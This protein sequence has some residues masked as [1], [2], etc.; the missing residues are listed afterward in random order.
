[1][2]R[3][4]HLFLVPGDSPLGLRLPL[5]S[6]P[7]VSASE[8]PQFFP[9]DPTAALP[10]L[11]V[12]TRDPALQ[13]RGGDERDKKPAPGESAP[14]IVRSALCVEPRDGRMHIFT[15]PQF[16]TEDYLDL[17]AAIEDTAAHLGTPVVIEGYTPP[18]DHRLNRISVTPDPGVIEVNVHPAHNWSELVGL[19]TS[20]YED[21]R[22]CRLG[23]EKFMLD[24]RHTGTGGG[25]H[26]VLG[27]A[28]PADSPF[29]RR[30]DLLRSM[31]GYWLNHP[32]LS[33]LFSGMFIGPTS[34]APRIDEGRNDNLYELEIAFSQ[35][36]LPGGHHCPPWLVDRI[37]RH[38]LVDLTGNTHRAEFCIDKLYSPDSA[39]GRLGLV[40]MRGFEM[41]PHPRMSLTQQL[42][43]RAFV[44][45]FW[46]EPYLHEP[47]DWGTQLHDR[48][49]LP[50][51]VSADF[52]EVLDDLR[53][54]GY[55]FEPEWF[56]PH[57][58]FRYPL[59][60]RVNYASVDI[61]LRQAIEPW[62]VLG[63]EPAGGATARFVDSS[64]ERLQVKVDSL[65]SDRYLIACNGRR[66]PLQPT[67]IRGQWVAGVRY[68]AWQ[69]PSC[70]HPTIPVHTPLVFDVFDTWSGRSI[71]GCAYHV[72]HPG[73]RHYESFPVNANE[74]EARRSARFF[75]FGHTPGPMAHPAEESNRQF[76]TT[77]DL[78]RPLPFDG[79]KN[80]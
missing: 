3:G 79:R 80:C 34:Q 45:W 1:M 11:P 52:R 39:S 31:L 48:F 15:P 67:S 66:I 43:V 28:T 70:L 62:Y 5:T 60:G 49:M 33:Y 26:F 74:A 38:I 7:W 41:P 20:L 42:L 14:W 19:T 51:F 75:A 76:P 69:P 57:F 68:R 13:S 58:E 27:A 65:T 71:G 22:Q 18:P 63:E 44:A 16:R 37:F 55:P 50:Y 10:P 21:T 46:R 23:T 54:A 17:L 6:L 36:P 59:Y 29:L 40:E 35:I 72:G 2:L 61:E 47:I 77:L 4:Q 9:V 24:G 32:S 8:A 56:A 73:G 12:P 78:R 64:V 25:N 53:R 30:P